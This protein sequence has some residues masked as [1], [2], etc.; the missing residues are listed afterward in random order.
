MGHKT[1]KQKQR[2]WRAYEQAATAVACHLCRDFINVGA[3]DLA[4]DYRMTKLNEVG[5]ALALTQA[6]ERVPVGACLILNFGLLAQ[7]E[8]GRSRHHFVGE[9]MAR[10][11]IP[12][13]PFGVLLMRKHWRPIDRLAHALLQHGKL[14]EAEA[15]TLIEVNPF[16]PKQPQASPRLA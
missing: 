15:L 6:T 11:P 8:I 4:A 5:G 16:K 9:D 1:F 13:D 2:R 10:L 7:I 3:I 14:D 12:G